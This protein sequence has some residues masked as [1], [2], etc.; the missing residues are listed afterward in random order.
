MAYLNLTN[1]T[2]LDLTVNLVPLAILAFMDVLFWVVNPWGWDPFI[3]VVSHFLTLFHL[4]L[5]AI[6]TYVSGLFV[7][8]DEGKVAEGE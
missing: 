1:E 2:W 6:L 7:Q 4:L 5:L 3:I 8:R